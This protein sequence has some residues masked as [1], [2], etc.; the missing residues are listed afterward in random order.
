MA[1]I[2]IDWR[3]KPSTLRVFGLAGIVAFG[4][5]GAAAWWR[6]YPLRWVSEG[7]SGPTGTVLFVLAGYCAVF[8]AVYPKALRPVYLGLTLL[9]FPIGFVVGHV[10]VGIVYY[11]ILTPVGLVF[12]LVGRDAMRRKF[13]PDA[14]SYWIKRKPPADN[15][16]YFRQ[17]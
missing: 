4:F 16:R 13:D 2:E 5:F 11:V 17:F 12:K 3:P 6:F 8:A 10:I 14:P 1:L 9:T 15:R 7:A